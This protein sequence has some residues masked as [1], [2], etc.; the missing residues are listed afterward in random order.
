MPSRF[1]SDTAVSPVGGGRYMARIDPGWWVVRGPNGGYVAAIVLRALIAETGDEVRVPRSLTV[2]FTRP[3]EP[4]PVD[5]AVT[6]ERTGRSLTT[7]SAHMTQAGRLVAVGVAALATDRPG[8]SFNDGAPP[9]VPAP[10]EVES[11]VL[12]GPDIPLHRQYET[13]WAIRLPP[14]PGEATRADQRPERAEVGGWIRL[15]DP[16]PLDHCVVAALTDAWMPAVFGRFTEPMAAPTI[17]LTVHFRRPPTR[18]TGWSLVRF[19]SSLATAGFVEEDG[20]VWSADGQLL[21]QSR[22][23][24]MLMPIADGGR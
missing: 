3:P 4:G 6:T 19:V 11:V 12:D 20:E 13:R 1:A 24:S 21:A 23:L 5:L 18:S 14:V 9:P 8:P 16:E 7:L 22:Q 17:D 2:H 15:S 10:E